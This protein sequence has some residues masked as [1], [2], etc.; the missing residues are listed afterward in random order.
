MYSIN[1]TVNSLDNSDHV[2]TNHGTFETMVTLGD[3]VINRQTGHFGT[4]VGYGH[5]MINS[6]YTPTLKVRVV[7][8]PKDNKKGFIKEDLFF[9]WRK[10]N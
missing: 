3:Y 7:A 4:V 9:N 10:Q 6:V 1:R 5:E 2:P 8:E